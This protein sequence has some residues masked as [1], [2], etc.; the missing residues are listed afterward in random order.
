MTPVSLRA[1]RNVDLAR[2]DD[3]DKSWLYFAP[4]SIVSARERRWF[5]VTMPST[6]LVAAV[7]ADALVGTV[8]RFV[9]LSG[10]TPLPGWQTLVIFTYAMVSCPVVNDVV[11]VAMIKWR[12]P[13]A[14]V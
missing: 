14:V 7:V 10:L 8:L 4:F 12:V 3:L 13:T 6:T 5:W 2:L 9:G 11:K 1:Q